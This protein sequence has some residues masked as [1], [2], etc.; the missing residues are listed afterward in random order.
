MT[1]IHLI[2]CGAVAAF[3]VALAACGDRT[4]S[5]AVVD[6]PL[7]APERPFRIEAGVAP[8]EGA[9]ITAG[10]V[11]LGVDREGALNVE[12]GQPSSMIDPSNGLS[13]TVVGLRY[14]PLNLAAIEQGCGCEGWGVADDISKEFGG[15]NTAFDADPDYVN[16]TRI[17]V[18][19]SFK[20]TPHSA[21]SQVRVGNRFRVTHDYHPGSSPNIVEA[22]VTIENISSATVDLLYRR[23]IDWDIEPTPFNELVTIVRGTSPRI[24]RYSTNPFNPASPFSFSAINPIN[25]QTLDTNRDVF[26]KG[27]ADLGALFDFRFGALAPGATRVF[28]IY[29]GAAASE[30]AMI[31]AL[32]GSGVEAYSIARAS[33]ATAPTTFGFGFRGIEGVAFP[34][35]GAPVVAPTVTGTIGVTGWY[36]SDVT[37]TWATSGGFGGAL[38]SASCPTVT[39][40]STGGTTSCTATNSLGV[41]VTQSVTIKQD[42]SLPCTVTGVSNPSITANPGNGTMTGNPQVGNN[43]NNKCV[44][45]GAQSSG[46]R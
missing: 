17:P 41:S 26:Y 36:T 31:S 25:H 16:Q 2:R 35:G 1:H 32:A 10:T 24:Y 4:P 14:A 6:A 3:L 21:V 18:V 27:P 34:A 44:G 13:N 38:V 40:P 15:R 22:T 11:K 46:G 33:Q 12:A 43:G 19:E 37:V 23:T 7:A 28:Y 45:L 42:A 39:V 29:Y 20:S 8:T 30:T 5:T 9:V